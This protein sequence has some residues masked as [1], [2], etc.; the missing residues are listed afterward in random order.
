MLGLKGAQDRCLRE[1]QTRSGD[2]RQ[3]GATDAQDHEDKRLLVRKA[4]SRHAPACYERVVWR[5]R[6]AWRQFRTGNDAQSIKQATARVNSSIS[7][8]R[9]RLGSTLA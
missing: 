5:D 4:L 9:L 7:K 6:L 8:G 3:V 2:V 1:S